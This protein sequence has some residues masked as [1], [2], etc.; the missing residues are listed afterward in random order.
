MRYVVIRGRNKGAIVEVDARNYTKRL[1][2]VKLSEP[3]R[4]Y[5]RFAFYYGHG[6]QLRNPGY[7]FFVTKKSLEKVDEEPIIRKKIKILQNKLLECQLMIK[8]RPDE[9]MQKKIL[10]C[11]DV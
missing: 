5:E 8:K 11:V 7:Y 10:E 1:A 9:E 6:R 2:C 3:F 4:L